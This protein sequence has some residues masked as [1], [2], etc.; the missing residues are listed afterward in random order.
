MSRK[1][2]NLRV[3]PKILIAD[4]LAENR[5]LLRQTLEPEGYDAFMVPSGELALQIAHRVQPDLI[6]LDV[7]MP[8]GMNGFET[9]AALKK[10]PITASIPIIFIS[11]KD[12][13]EDVVESFRV[14]AVDY[15]RKPFQKEEV[16]ARVRTHLHLRQ[17]ARELLAR[18][19]ELTA[20]IARREKVEKEL[21][22]ADEQL[23]IISEQEAQRWGIDAFVGRS[24]TLHRILEDVRRVQAAPATSVL[25]SGESGT[26]K[27][28]I[29][30]AI[31]FGGPRAQGPFVPINCSAI[32]KELA[33]AT[34][35]GH[36]EGAFTGAK[37]SRRGCFETA[38]GGTLFLDEIGEME[39][40]LQAKVLRVLED[41]TIQRLGSS[42]SKQINVR[43]VAATN[44]D[45][46]QAIAQGRFRQDI[47]FR[48]ARFTI[49]LPPL[50][51][52]REDIPLL[53]EHFLKL[54]AAEMGIA[55]PIMTRA[56]R[57]AIEQYSYPG[58]VRELKNIIEHALIRGGSEID[59]GHLSFLPEHETPARAPKPELAAPQSQSLFDLNQDLRK[60][61]F[62]GALAETGG[63]PD[64]AAQLL[65]VP[66]FEIISALP[67]TSRGGGIRQEKA[68][69]DRLRSFLQTYGSINNA[70]CCELLQIDSDRAYTLLT[71]LCQAG[72]L[73]RTGEKRWARYSASD[74][75]PPP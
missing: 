12:E 56:A 64:Q 47:Y 10:D 68:F 49:R 3:R 63:D 37:M 52:R 35:F 65:Q 2:L 4:D 25:I 17:L 18:N 1:S 24:P 75:Q 23:S 55:H 7:S 61:L 41:G 26:G 72:K 6:L 22:R 71:K 57:L 42:Q 33:E 69:E 40:E 46:S 21:A 58:N 70:E 48:L 67:E 11:V 20:E 19:E 50:R 74:N 14:G 62:R 28:L 27:E 32:P 15:I 38:D 8:G 5:D 9:C 13:I 36:V 16:V 60:L 59:E 29:A 44:R 43:V 66:V 34:L 30:R 45:L 73:K 54:L 51:E 53:A 39:M 31:H